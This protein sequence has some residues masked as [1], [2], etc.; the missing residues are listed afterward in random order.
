L[1]ETRPLPAPAHHMAAM[2]CQHANVAR[3]YAAQVEKIARQITMEVARDRSVADLLRQLAE[4]TYRLQGE[5][6]ALDVIDEWASR[7]KRG[8][9]A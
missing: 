6:R 2:R 5:Q 4:Y 3:R 7:M 1:S 8:I 9:A